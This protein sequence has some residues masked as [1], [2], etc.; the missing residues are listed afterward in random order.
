MKADSFFT[1]DRLYPFL[2]YVSQTRMEAKVD[3]ILN[4]SLLFSVSLVELAN[5]PNM[6]LH[7]GLFSSTR[8]ELLSPLRCFTFL[9]ASPVLLDI[10]GFEGKGL[11]DPKHSLQTRKIDN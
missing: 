6:Q 11:L 5:Y 3:T 8:G 4:L 7:M 9:T 2:R 1:K 10:R